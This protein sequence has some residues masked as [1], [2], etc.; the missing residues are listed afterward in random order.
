[1]EDAFQPWVR[2]KLD[3][4][5]S[6]KPTRVLAGETVESIFDM[7]DCVLR[8]FSLKLILNFNGHY[9]LVPLNKL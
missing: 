2:D 4:S 1:M 9:G 8:Q 7:S 5:Y 6:F 3:Q